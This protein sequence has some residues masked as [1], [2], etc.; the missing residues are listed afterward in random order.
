VLRRSELVA[1]ASHELKT[2]LTTIRMILML[3]GEGS[4]TFTE[5]QREILETAL[6]GCEELGSTTDELLDVTR[7]EAGQFRLDLAPVDLSAILDAVLRLLRTR[8]DDAEVRIEVRREAR[9]AIVSGDP[10]RLRNVMTNILAN[11]LKYSPRGA[12]S[13]RG[14]LSARY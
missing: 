3:L 9:P 2:P 11:A 6:L 12:R 10:T 8:I 1:V 13:R 5:R 14:R 4:D 7:I